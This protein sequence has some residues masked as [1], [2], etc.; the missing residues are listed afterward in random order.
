MSVLGKVGFHFQERHPFPGIHLIFQAKFVLDKVRVRF[1]LTEPSLFRFVYKSLF[2]M[3]FVSRFD[4]NVR[5]SSRG[6]FFISGTF[7]PRLW[8]VRLSF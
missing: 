3:K 5:F 7:V 1:L 2:L 8:K 4:W 6:S